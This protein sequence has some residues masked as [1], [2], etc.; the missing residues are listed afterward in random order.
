MNLEFICGLLMIVLFA[1]AIS[2]RWLA[3]FVGLSIVPLIFAVIYCVAT[4]QS[5]LTAFEWAFAGAFGGEL[6]GGTATSAIMILFACTYFTFMMKVGLFDPLI[7]AIIKL[8]K[9]DPLK[10]MVAATCVAGAVSLDG[11]GASTVLITTAAFVPLFKQ[12]N[13]RVGYLAV[14]IA[15]PT[16]VFNMMPWGGSFARC[17]SA[18][19]LEVPE[20]LAPLV[21]GLVV[22][23]IYAIGV[24]FFLGRKERER[25]GYDPKA[26]AHVSV[27]EIEKM[28]DIVRNNDPEFKRPHLAWFNLIVTLGIMVL[29]VQGLANSAVLFMAGLGI[30][31]VVNLGF[32]FKI[33]KNLL[34]DCLVE[35]V[36]V[37]AMIVASGFLMG[38]LLYSGMGD[39][40]AAVLAS[41]VPAGAARFIPYIIA[42]LGIP[43]LIFTGPD[44]FYFGL[45]PVLAQLA[46]AYGI[47]ATTIGVAAM[48]S[49]STFYCSPLIAWI[50]LLCSRCEIE[51]ADYQ[52][53]LIKF[54]LPAFVIYLVVYTLTGGIAVF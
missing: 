45:V 21:P 53:L 24:G 7:I 3:P 52:K 22:V 16:S 34:D 48:V 4:G 36:S 27:E 18:L 8:V 47:S 17:I 11:D 50:F 32:N 6:T 1:V 35:G 13:M 42:I 39:A 28:C 23:M 43:L 37:C 54:A 19:G 31:L 15:L 12:L 40:I 41:I 10:V 26:A 33:Q 2:K 20:L 49:L 46:A 5:P 44:V 30:T 25:L 14:L 38:I 51:F 29:L 9:G